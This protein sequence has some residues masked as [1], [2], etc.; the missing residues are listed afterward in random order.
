MY[1][2]G[3]PKYKDYVDIKNAILMQ[4]NG[5]VKAEF[6]FHERKCLKGYI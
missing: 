4:R 2:E 3:T 1:V 5:F 6:F